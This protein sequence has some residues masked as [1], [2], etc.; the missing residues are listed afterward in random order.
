MITLSRFALSA[1]LLHSLANELLASD[2]LT[3]IDTGLTIC[4]VRSAVNRGIPYL[5]AS[6]YEGTVLGVSFQGKIGWKN[7]LSGF[8]NRDL[9]CADLTGDGA[10]EILAANADGSVYC[11][12][13]RGELQWTFRPSDAP[14][15]TVCVIRKDRMPYVVCGGYDTNIYYLDGQG[16][17]VKTIESKSYS[18]EKPWGKGERRIPPSS[19]H[20][21]NF[22]RPVR[23]ADGTE[24]LAVHGV[25]YSNSARGRLYLFEPLHER[26]Y[27][28]IQ[29]QGGVGELRVADLDGDGNEEIV[30]G[31]TSMIQDAHVS[32]LV[33]ATGAS[34]HS[35]FPACVAGSTGLATG[36]P[37][38]KSL[39][40]ETSKGCSCSSA[41]RCFCY[42][43]TWRLTRHRSQS[44]QIGFPITT[45][46]G[47]Q[48]RTSSCWPA[49]KA[50]AVA[51]TCSESRR[52][53]VG[54]RRTRTCNRPARLPQSSPTPPPSMT[55]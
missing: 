46:G 28:V 36:L 37:S 38:R 13:H 33:S 39:R 5:V 52:S 11:L 26:P 47:R 32:V 40:T 41:R 48:G 25:I 20:V 16:K 10:D 6:S 22:L 43:R 15:N 44:F 24:V 4:K 42:R 53:A 55:S 49:L 23:R 17:P 1:W 54:R 19:S 31:S 50:A 29:A 30:T 12:D 14:M 7:A 2:A 35:I 34:G 27:R 9:W 8:M 21:A 3:S 45:C 51:C 18:L